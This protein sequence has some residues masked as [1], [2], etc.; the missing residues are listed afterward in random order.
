MRV[1]RCLT[2]L[3][4][5]A[6]LAGSP[7]AAW[8]APQ[9]ST[10]APAPAAG[11]PVPGTPSAPAKK[12][13]PAQSPEARAAAAARSSGKPVEILERRTATEQVIANP[14]GTTTTHVS[15]RPVRVQ[16]PDR[17][18]AAV[19]TALRRAGGRLVP[20]ATAADLSFSAGGTGP[21]ATMTRSGRSLSMSW[22]APLPAPSISGATATYADVLPGA[23]L[24]A[25][26]DVEGFSEQLVVRT[27]EALTALRTVRFGLSVSK[28][29]EARV[30]ADGSL[31]AVDDAG[32]V[33]FR[34]PPPVM[35][36]TPASAEAVA[37]GVPGPHRSTLAVRLTAGA[38][39]LVPDAK[40]LAAPDLRLPLI[41][42]PSWTT[43]GPAWTEVNSYDPNS[44]TWRTVPTSLAVGFQNFQPATRVRSFIRFPISS[45]IYG[46]QIRSATLRL[47]E[48][49]S[50]SCTART[51]AVHATSS[52][53]SS[54]T[55]NH[56]PTWGTLQGTAAVAHGYSSSC[57]A[58][59]IEFNVANAVAAAAKARGSVTLGLK[60][61][62]ENDNLAWKKFQVDGTTP[63][64]TIVYNRPPRT[65]GTAD[66]ST[67]NPTTSCSGTPRANAQNG[68]LLKVKASDPDGDKVRV[69]F[70]FTRVGGTPIS[71]TSAI[72]SS[73][74]VASYQVPAS[75]FSSA[76][77]QTFSWK[78]YVKDVDATTQASI[79]NS[80]WSPSCTFVHDGT[81]PSQPTVSSAE[82]P[83]NEYGV[84]AGRGGTFTIAPGAATETDIV[85]YN[86][87][88]DQ[89]S[90][91]T[92]VAAGG[93]G[94]TAT[95]TATP[96][97]WGPHDLF[98]QAKDSAG[99]LSTPYPYHFYVK[100]P[101]G[102]AGYW[103]FDDQ[104]QGAAAV[105]TVETAPTTTGP[106]AMLTGGAAWTA[107][108]VDGGLRFNGTTASAST[109]VH[110]STAAD[111]AVSAWVKLSSKGRPVT[112]VSEDSPGISG[113]LLQY[114]PEQDK[115]AFTMP[116]QD[117]T[118][119]YID[120]AWSTSPAVLDTWTHITGVY[121]KAQQKTGIYV[122]GALEGTATHA[123]SW[124]AT[125]TV[126]I[127]RG[128]SGGTN[129]D[130]LPGDVD[131]VR[132]YD[133]S[134]LDSEV[135]DIVSYT[136]PGP[137][138]SWRMDDGA[139][140]PAA[141]DT[142]GFN[143]PLTRGTGTTFV[144]GGHDNGCLN[145]N[146]TMPAT[147]VGVV[148]T[149]K[150]FSVSAW[151]RMSNKS[152]TY[153]AVSQA[154]TL[155]TRFVL[156][157]RADYD[158]W[159]FNLNSANAATYTVAGAVGTSVPVTSQWTFLAGTWDAATNQAKLYVNGKLEATVTTSA[160]WASP[161]TFLAGSSK[162]NGAIVN[163]W[164]GQ[165]DE[166]KVFG[167]GLYAGEAADLYRDG[168]N[169]AN[170]STPNGRWQLD[171]AAGTT[172]ALDTSGNNKPMTLSGTAAFAPAGGRTAGA[173][174][175]TPTTTTTPEGDVVVTGGGAA[176]TAF[177][178]VRSDR[179][180]AV[181]AWVKLNDT[182]REQTVVSQDG[183]NASSFSLSYVP[184]NGGLWRFTLPQSD[185]AGSEAVEP[186]DQT[187]EDGTAGT[188]VHLLA[189][190]DSFTRQTRLWVADSVSTRV[191]YG[192]QN[193][194]WQGSGQLVLGRDKT[195]SD[196]DAD[197][198]PTVA[199]GDWLNG[200]VDEVTL[201]FG[202]LSAGDVATLLAQ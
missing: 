16:R 199:P 13:A 128:R 148:D 47:Y 68:I 194:P 40:V 71:S 185:V 172:T 165:I 60:A 180:F 79:S 173:L 197:G 1:R 97:T 83:E 66:L 74:G 99:N 196:P 192:V 19:D 200:S 58:A 38:L 122:N 186:A 198:V 195:A 118:S 18:W 95:V 157:Y 92:Y 149:T 42:D 108:R 48:N 112:V 155:T 77:G 82:Y 168:R 124:D 153:A 37:A 2:V 53:T 29:L 3:G 81:R 21:F 179:S 134:L 23:D 106:P 88:L 6:V 70:S 59:N 160:G 189:E 141:A 121:W 164:V 161:T 133:R 130:Y 169:L 166:V 30:G 137:V 100:A 156:A 127:G 76:Q 174:T 146:A 109:P 107:G 52:F 119:T 64:L 101:T 177:S 10:P 7:S 171:E 69:V 91:T 49:W 190:Y 65:P 144:A 120:I 150:T 22:P 15:A 57:P 85:G 115:F 89:A 131:E 4:I 152:G 142:S 147:G 167:R 73:G 182:D 96:A 136:K 9:P 56:Q 154:G 41:I 123:T 111:L 36:D 105:G 51:M 191:G 67:S 72:F 126:Q 93:T 103:K 114:R 116:Q 184:E 162:S 138:A 178:A 117:A 31:T 63:Q 140:Q 201:Y 187:M 98:V 188:W 43:K 28:G 145:V 183:L 129:A 55:W 125:G 46:T 193:N 45:T 135:A 78:A 202:A 8:A 50:S 44:S 102:A 27:K 84:S 25:T 33:V 94:R 175:T 11:T 90:P 132:V 181:S 34:S 170:V 17:S 176:N 14:D 87:G 163:K 151:V 159:V 62:D 158:R 26:A 12:A 20:G 113:F 39:E 35:W 61:T 104:P 54:T 86:Y 80:G 5:G 32:G 110:V 143:H 24:K 139:S 75:V